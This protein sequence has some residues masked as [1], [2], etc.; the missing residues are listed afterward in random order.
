[1]Y[2]K[3]K[4]STE[5]ASWKCYVSS[6]DSSAALFHNHESKNDLELELQENEFWGLKLSVFSKTEFK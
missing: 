3:E 2:V 5:V 4:I 6:I 1:M